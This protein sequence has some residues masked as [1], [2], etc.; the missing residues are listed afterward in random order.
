MPG[1]RNTAHDSF[2]FSYRWGLWLP[3][4]GG[5]KLT[6]GRKSGCAVAVQIRLPHPIT[7][8]KPPN[9]S[10][11]GRP[12]AH[13]HDSSGHRFCV[14]CGAGSIPAAIANHIGFISFSFATPGFS[15]HCGGGSQPG[16][17]IPWIPVQLRKP[18]PVRCLLRRRTWFGPP[19]KPR[20]EYRHPSRKA[21]FP[22]RGCFLFKK[23]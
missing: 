20:E 18:F 19:D 4:C 9:P 1:G 23:I 17:D 12:L 2:L 3:Q 15:G 6:H 14:A 21:P 13:N 22:N 16:I 11:Q 7:S 8:K 5:T 10:G